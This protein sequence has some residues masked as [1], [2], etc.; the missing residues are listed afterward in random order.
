LQELERAVVEHRRRDARDHVGAERLL[1]VED[2]PYGARLAGLEGGQ[3]GA[4]GPVSGSSSVATTVVVPRS[5]A[6]AKRRPLVSPGST[7]MSR[8]SARTAVTFQAEGRSVA[9]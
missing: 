6:A 5:Y 1:H 7:S 3:R 8:S 9:P 2:G 4:G